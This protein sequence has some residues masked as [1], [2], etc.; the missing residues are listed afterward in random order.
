LLVE[1]K[2]NEVLVMLPE[3]PSGGRPGAMLI[4]LGFT[5]AIVWFGMVK[6]QRGLDHA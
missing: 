5:L 2:R 4:A 1:P 3:L 6:S